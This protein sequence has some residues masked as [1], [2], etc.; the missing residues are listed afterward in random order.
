V[1]PLLGVEHLTVVARVANGIAFC[2]DG[3]HRRAICASSIAGFNEMT[4]RAYDLR[5]KRGLM[6][7]SKKY[8]LLISHREQRGG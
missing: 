8:L 5:A 3:Y 4:E 6:R 2:C 1:Q 7:R